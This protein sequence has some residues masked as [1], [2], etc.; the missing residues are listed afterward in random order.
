MKLDKF[1]EVYD[2]KQPPQA[3]EPGAENPQA[4]VK[5]PIK[6]IDS[7]SEE[8]TKP[9][10]TLEMPPNIVAF[11]KGQEVK[12]K[13]FDYQKE[14]GALIKKTMALPNT[15]KE[16]QKQLKVLKYYQTLDTDNLQKFHDLFN[17]EDIKTFDDFVGAIKKIYGK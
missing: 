4:V 15:S 8:Q 5:P 1:L 6:P 11:L 16:K 10:Q 7:S 14:I 13:N 17:R 2:I 12:D 3:Q 9:P